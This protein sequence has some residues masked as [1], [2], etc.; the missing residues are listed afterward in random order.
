MPAPAHRLR[1]ARSLGDRPRGASA[2][3][4]AVTLVV[5]LLASTLVLFGG[6]SGAPTRHGATPTLSDALAPAP[7][8][9]AAPTRSAAAPSS[10]RTLPNPLDSSSNVPCLSINATICISVVNASIPDIIPVP[11]THVSPVHPLPNA[12]ISLWVRS[13]YTLAWTGNVS[14]SGPHS[15][16]SLNATGTLWN[17]V[18]Y[19]NASDGTMWHP[20]GNVWWTYGPPGVNKTYPYYYGLTFSSRS[21]AGT[22][23]FFPGMTLT[24]WI[25][26]VQNTS[27]VYSHNSTVH[28]QFTFGGAWP[29]SPY[30]AAPQYGGTGAAQEDL[31]VS[32]TPLAPN[33]N[34]SVNVTIST[35]PQDLFTGA[36]IG[37]A[38]LDVTESAPDGAVLNSTT[39]AFKVQVEGSQ[40]SPNGTVTLPASLAGSPGAL[41]TY[42]V[43]AWDMSQYAAGQIGPDAITLSLFNYTVNGNGTFAS[44]RFSNDLSLTTNPGLPGLN[45][46]SSGYVPAG[47][48][49]VLHLASTSTT[50]AI[51]AAEADLTFTFP[52][53]NET[54]AQQIPL[55]RVNST[56]FLGMIPPVPIGSEVSFEMVA[57]DFSQ[58]REVSTTNFTY[59]TDPLPAFFA[60][61]PSNSTFFVVNVYDN[62]TGKWVNGADVTFTGVAGSGYLRTES[63]TFG[64]VTYPNATGA[65]FVPLLLSA[66]ASYRIVV[67]DSTF[68]PGGVG[69]A[70]S[71]GVTLA[72]PHAPSR[73]GIVAVGPTYAIAENGPYLY[74]WL[75]QSYSSVTYS[76]PN[77]VTSTLT[78]EAGVGLVAVALAGVPLYFWWATIRARR[79]EQERRITL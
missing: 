18:P 76:A 25:Y 54:V 22:P 37:G 16:L 15:P 12:T 75:N 71:V 78:F 46:R 14:T 57:W 4:A 48:A 65:A 43:T 8:R 5:V 24:W 36:S 45:N 1:V 9:A 42:R 23:N 66:D 63:R 38:Y 62:G 13:V 39:F 72:M 20:T 31:A 70:P 7:G 69:P 55:H 29:A 3:V 34:D 26:F 27:G 10:D 68:L 30:P 74:F 6:P 41:I 51:E 17:G 79:L 47:T 40:G 32:Q 60:A 33:Y 73:T 11:G 53:I 28:F 52:A 64:G 21:L 50:T 59:S 35:T 77:S 2:R 19:Y 61:V 58:N 49:I 44:G 56:H 67:N